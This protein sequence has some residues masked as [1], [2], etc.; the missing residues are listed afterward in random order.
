[1]NIRRPAV[2]T[3]SRETSL[4][5]LALALGVSVVLL[6]LGV[7]ASRAEDLGDG[8]TP[9]PKAVAGQQTLRTMADHIARGEPVRVLAI[10]S[11]STEGIGATSPAGSYPRR[12][13]SLLQGVFAD[14]SITVQNAGIG[15]ETAEATVARLEAVLREPA[16][17]DLVIWQ[18]G[19]N[20]AVKGGSEESF[21]ALLERGVAAAQHAE[22]DLILLDQQFY[23]GIPDVSRY[24]RFVQA[25][26]TVAEKAKVGLFSR[27]QLMKDWFAAD[28]RRLTMML[29]DDRFHMS[30][31]GYQCL[32]SNLGHEIASSIG[33]SLTPSQLLARSKRF[34]P[35][36][37][38]AIRRT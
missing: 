6:G 16:K 3:R 33:A 18:V 13:E 21:R 10:G 31:R 28:P 7:C 25:V 38:R 35:A 24:E 4:R 29:S 2:A 1:M 32:A 22:V 37:D 12:L 11:S 30:D 15:G 14:A 26:K 8:C 19:T 34:A 5:V 27:Y 36:I 20:D 17:P 9:V 23:S